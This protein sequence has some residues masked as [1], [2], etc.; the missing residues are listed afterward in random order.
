MSVQFLCDRPLR[1]P[2]VL[3]LAGPAGCGKSTVAS[4]LAGRGGWSRESFAAPLRELLLRLEPTLDEWHL[5]PGKD[6]RRADGG[7]SPREQMRA[8]GDWIKA[9]Q[10][11]FF[12]DIMRRKLAEA[13]AAGRHVAI[14]DVR[15]EGEARLIRELGGTVVHVSRTDIAFRRDHNSEMGV[16]PLMG[17]LHLRNWDGLRTLNSELGYLLDAAWQERLALGA[18]PDGGSDVLAGA[19]L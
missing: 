12:A 14:D 1:F 8:A 9:Y 3:G 19:R 6:M 15:F 10:P 11:G 5:G 7:P 2:V 4:L 17:D 13:E 16:E 18:A